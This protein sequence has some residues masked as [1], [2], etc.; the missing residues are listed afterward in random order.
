MCVLFL[1]NTNIKQQVLYDLPLKKKKVLFIWLVQLYY[2][3]KKKKKKRKKKKSIHIG[4]AKILAKFNFKSHFST[5]S[6][7]FFFFFFFFFF[8]FWVTLFKYYLSIYSILFTN[9]LDGQD[10]PP[11]YL[12]RLATPCKDLVISQ[13]N[14]PPNDQLAPTYMP[15]ADITRL[16]N[17]SHPWLTMTIPCF[18]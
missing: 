15:N 4:L 14:Q 13:P 17:N 2:L 1:I 7:D 5:P 9:K 6:S 16:A 12:R 3:L 11:F 18:N 10:Q 8:L